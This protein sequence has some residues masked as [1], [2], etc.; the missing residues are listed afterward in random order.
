MNPVEKNLLGNTLDQN[1][2]L[3]IIH[4]AWI[5]LCDKHTEIVAGK[6]SLKLLYENC[7]E[8]RFRRKLSDGRRKLIMPMT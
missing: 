6:K 8:S 5:V 1:N 2:C 7:A 3:G 4:F